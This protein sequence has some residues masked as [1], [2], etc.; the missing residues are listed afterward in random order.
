MKAGRPQ[1]RV[2]AARR[3]SRSPVAEPGEEGADSGRAA[4]PRQRRRHRSIIFSAMI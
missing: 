1:A 4:L 3:A 2:A